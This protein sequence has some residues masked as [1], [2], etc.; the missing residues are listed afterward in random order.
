MGRWTQF[1]E[2]SY[3]LPEGMKRIGYDADTKVYT[4]RDRNGALYVG[5]PEADYGTL[6]PVTETGG[7]PRAGAFESDEPR[8]VSSV[9]SGEIPSTFHDILPANLITA[10]TS[11]VD[12]SR[13][14]SP[15][16]SRISNGSDGNSGSPR[17]R[18]IDAARRSALPK[19]QGFVHNLRRSITSTRRKGGA[20]EEDETLLR[21]VSSDLQRSASMA[22]ARSGVS[23]DN[24]MLVHDR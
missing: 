18:F 6:T 5:E 14:S 9:S 12:K 11:P 15:T 19:M 22:T 17:A 4:F 24:P 8:K 10:T 21:G 1:E 23:V 3:R 7:S 2:D 16:A 20:A 13:L